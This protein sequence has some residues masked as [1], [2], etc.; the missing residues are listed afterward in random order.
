MT[1]MWNPGDPIPGVGAQVAVRCPGCEW[2]S[3]V[4]MVRDEPNGAW[5]AYDRAAHNWRSHWRDVHTPSPIRLIV[6]ETNTGS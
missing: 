3:G 4:E 5:F 2:T 6:G 1:A